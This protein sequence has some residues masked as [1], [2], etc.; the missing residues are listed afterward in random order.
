MYTKDLS[1]LIYS[2]DIQE[3]FI[4]KLGI[5]H[6]TFSNSLRTGEIYLNRYIFTNKPVIG[7]KFNNMSEIEIKIMLEKK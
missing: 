4:F 2:S 5:H 6:S 7:A 1:E 3:D